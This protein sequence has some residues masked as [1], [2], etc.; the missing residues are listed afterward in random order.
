M[1]GKSKKIISRYCPFREWTGIS[2]GRKKKRIK[3]RRKLLFMEIHS[4][5][6]IS[7]CHW[8]SAEEI[9]RGGWNSGW[10]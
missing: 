9:W 2:R 4:I 3:T 5:E 6:M 1:D 8:V 7:V 10:L